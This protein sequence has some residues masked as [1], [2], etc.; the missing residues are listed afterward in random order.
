M[1][2]RI[3]C[4]TKSSTSK[5]LTSRKKNY[6]PKIS[7]K[8]SL[9]PL[10][11]FNTNK[12]FH[13]ANN[14][15]PYKI[16]LKSLLKYLK[17]R[18]S[19]KLYED[20]ID[21]IQR[22][23]FKFNNNSIYSSN[24]KIDIFDNNNNNCNDNSKTS[25]TSKKTNYTLTN[26]EYDSYPNINN[27]LNNTVGAINQNINIKNFHLL[28]STLRKKLE[29]NL[30]LSLDFKTERIKNINYNESKLY[31]IPF[32]KSKPRKITSMSIL[33]N[34]SKIQPTPNL[35]S[36]RA[37]DKIKKITNLKSKYYLRK[38]RKNDSSKEKD[39][40][41]KNNKPKSLSKITN[42]DKVYTAKNK[43]FHKKIKKINLPT[44]QRIKDRINNCKLSAKKERRLSNKTKNNVKNTTAFEIKKKKP[45]INA[46]LLSKLINQ[47]I[48]LIDYKNNTT[49]NKTNRLLQ[50]KIG[51]NN[52]IFKDSSEN[53][54]SK[55]NLNNSIENNKKS[56]VKKLNIE[57]NENDGT[58]GCV[59]L[60]SSYR[61][62][63]AINEEILKTVRNNLEDSMKVMLN[64]SYGDFLSKESE[65]ES[66]D[67][68]QHYAFNIVDKGYDN[69][70]G[71]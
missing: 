47:K 53:G 42:N 9:P 51:S 17:K 65:Q 56:E 64:F 29:K 37:F 21:F 30:K 26:C 11:F 58:D 71:Q 32:I 20:I 19:E 25:K 1:K 45:M 70:H 39:S 54:K 18:L 31:Y 6:Q 60:P 50:Y 28:D 12:N 43:Q 27:C 2:K 66:K 41:K 35:S 23:I 61:K 44:H 22:Q 34:T 48:T 15:F 62:N 10:S 49:K 40:F 5:I 36:E 52:F 16:L 67:L 8:S 7:N 59:N 14:Y 24:P 13:N 68:S 63:V 4:N 46:K 57:I 38:N 69:N 55:K 3:N 33:L